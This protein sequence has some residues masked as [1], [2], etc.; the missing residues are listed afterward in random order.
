ME[1]VTYADGETQARKAREAAVAKRPPEAI[2]P[3]AVGWPRQCDWYWRTAIQFFQAA[4]KFYEAGDPAQGDYCVSRGESYVQLAVLCT[5]S[6]TSDVAPR[7]TDI[8]KEHD[9]KAGTPS[10]SRLEARLEEVRGLIDPKAPLAPTV[11]EEAANAEFCDGFY[12]EAWDF[13][14]AAVAA[15]Q[16]GDSV[17]YHYW[18]AEADKSLAAWYVC[19]RVFHPTPTG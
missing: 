16:A 14:A 4:Q 1:P 15:L 13:A 17:A 18:L 12:Y 11:Q 19:Q 3:A 6:S 10:L 9:P 7:R 2:R 5:Y 8:P